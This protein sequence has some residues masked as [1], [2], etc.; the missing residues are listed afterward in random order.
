MTTW[1]INHLA[2]HP[3]GWL[4]ILWLEE[5]GV[6]SPERKA[7][8]LQELLWKEIVDP[9]RQEQNEVE[10]KHRE[11]NKNNKVAEAKLNRRIKWYVAYRHGVLQHQDQFLA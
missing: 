6:P 2:D 7:S 3:G 4:A 1:G 8:V 5:A 10:V 11:K 9:I